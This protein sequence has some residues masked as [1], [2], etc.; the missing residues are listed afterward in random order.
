[1]E[2]V[3]DVGYGATFHDFGIRHW[4]GENG[5]GNGVVEDG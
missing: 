3:D 2:V 4:S 5:V 1:V